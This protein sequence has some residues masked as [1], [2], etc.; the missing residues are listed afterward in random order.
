MIYCLQIGDRDYM[1]FSMMFGIFVDFYREHLLISLALLL[2]LVYLLIRKPKTFLLLLGITALF[3]GV[4]Y[5]WMFLST[6][7]NNPIWK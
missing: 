4:I 7:K 2:I 3:M 5:F 6:E 1:D